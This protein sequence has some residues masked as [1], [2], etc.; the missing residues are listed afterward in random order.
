M[1]PL[2]LRF[3][4]R[5]FS[6]LQEMIDTLIGEANERV[7]RIDLGEVDNIAQER[8]YIKIRLMHIERCDDE[9]LP[10]EIKA[11]MSSIWSQLYRLEHQETYVHPYLLKIL[12]QIRN[13][14]K[15]TID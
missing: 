1:N 6:S 7:I 11:I 4:G 12:E 2:C 10:K 8:L 3:E 9:D 15:T 13:G 5:E 14:N